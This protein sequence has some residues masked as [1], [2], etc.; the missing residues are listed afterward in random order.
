MTRPHNPDIIRKHPCMPNSDRDKIYAPFAALRGHSDSLREEDGKLLYEK[1][2]KLSPEDSEH[3]AEQIRKLTKDMHI[4]LTIFITEDFNNGD[5]LGNYVIKEGRV[6]K[7]D[8]F[9][10]KIS[11]CGEWINLDDIYTIE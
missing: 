7:I 8:L 4:R 11:I 5:Y 1:K 6:D 2:K 3:L 10:R 9:V